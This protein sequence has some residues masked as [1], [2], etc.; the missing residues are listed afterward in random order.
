[1][2]QEEHWQAILNRNSCYD[3]AIIYAVISTK[4]Y[5]LPSYPFRKPKRIIVG[6]SN[7]NKNYSTKKHY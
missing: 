1:M 4:I 5:C 6:E 2:I 7:V 3:R